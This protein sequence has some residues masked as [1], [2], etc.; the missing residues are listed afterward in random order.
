MDAD[1]AQLARLVGDLDV[2]AGEH[3]GRHPLHRASGG[4]FTDLLSVAEIERLLASGARRP[5]FRL[6][7]D[8]A[9]LPPGRSTAEVRLGGRVLD[10]VADLAAIAATVDAGATLVLQ[11]LQRTSLLLARFC[12][13]L[14]RAVS[15]PVQANAYL[16]PAGATGLAP[17]HDDHD[18][19]VLQVE[20]AKA[21]HV[22]GL[23]PLVA[24]AGDV[25]YLPAG[26][27][28]HARAQDGPSLHLTVGVVRVTREQALR[29]ALRA[30]AADVLDAPL[31]LGYARPERAAALAQDLRAAAVGLASALATV[32]PGAFAG[33]EARRATTRRRPLPLGQLESVLALGALRPESVVAR[34]PD[35]PAQVVT[36]PDAADRLTL[37]LVD[38][39]L[40]LPAAAGPA[41]DQLLADPKVQVGALRGLDAESQLVLARRLVREGLLVVQEV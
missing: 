19:L 3:W 32:D 12:R 29:R 40:R 39:R 25:V 37:E 4:A 34:R 23:G 15:H 26:V 14:E 38:R 28:H 7:Q 20:G 10:D 27:R 41:L 18:V 9:T 24:E 13:S 2:F 1:E 8:G 6:V 33:Q 31:P 35:H 30:V 21:W 36:E 11:G 22:D 5:T 17:H 16:T